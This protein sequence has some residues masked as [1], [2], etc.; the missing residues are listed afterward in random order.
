M[1]AEGGISSESTDIFMGR[2]ALPATNVVCLYVCC[3][4]LSS[5]QTRSYHPDQTASLPGSIL[6]AI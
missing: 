3:I 5:I 4:Y 1:I 6:F 2:L